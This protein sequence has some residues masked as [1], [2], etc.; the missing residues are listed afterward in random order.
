[1][2]RNGLFLRAAEYGRP[3]GGRGCGPGSRVCSLVSVPGLAVGSQAP[4]LASG[5]VSVGPMPLVW[6]RSQSG[7][8]PRG[9][10]PTPHREKQRSHTATALLLLLCACARAA[11][12]LTGS[13]SRQKQQHRFLRS[14]FVVSSFFFAFLRFSRWFTLFGILHKNVRVKNNR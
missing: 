4:G 8:V 10:T 13:D 3:H 14:F 9:P 11:F 1:M 12:G 6:S 5:L 7:V 2:Q